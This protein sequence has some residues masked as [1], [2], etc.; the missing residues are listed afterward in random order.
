MLTF[1]RSR[2]YINKLK[3]LK[4][5]SAAQV[6]VRSSSKTTKRTLYNVYLKT[7][8]VR[9]IGGR[10]VGTIIR[11]LRSYRGHTTDVQQQQQQQQRNDVDTK[12]TTLSSLSSTVRRSSSYLFNR[13]NKLR[14]R[15]LDK[16]SKLRTSQKVYNSKVNE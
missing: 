9:R 7:H 2:R 11:P 1:E 4:L 15:I 13:T 10:L 12:L 8:R 3:L 14:L 5:K 16:R 6:A